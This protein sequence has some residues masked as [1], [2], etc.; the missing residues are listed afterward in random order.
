MV[1]LILR[2]QHIILNAT[3]NSIVT[4]KRQAQS[5]LISLKI[6][7]LDYIPPQ[8]SN[9][10]RQISL[11]PKNPSL[12]PSSLHM[13][14]PASTQPYSTPKHP[15]LKNPPITQPPTIQATTLPTSLDHVQTAGVVQNHRM[16]RPQ[17]RPPRRSGK[18]TPRRGS[19]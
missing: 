15:P 13:A 12:D 4:S 11:Q 5:M 3:T 7:Q 1:K 9:P 2:S 10:Q 8:P 18:G 17:I 19:S 14:N 6:P 16:P